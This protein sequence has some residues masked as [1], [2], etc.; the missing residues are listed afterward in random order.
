MK[1]IQQVH[2]LMNFLCLHAQIDQINFWGPKIIF[3]KTRKNENELMT[4]AALTL[5][6]N[7][8]LQIGE[9]VLTASAEEEE[10]KLLILI[11]LQRQVVINSQLNEET[12]DLTLEFDDNM[13]LIVYGN[14]G[15]N[16][17]WELGAFTF[18]DY[19]GV[20][21]TPRKNLAVNLPENGEIDYTNG[22]VLFL[23]YSDE[24]I[25]VAQFENVLPI[26]EERSYSKGDLWHGHA[27]YIRRKRSSIQ[28]ESPTSKSFDVTEEVEQMM[29]LLDDKKD[30]ILRLKQKYNMELYIHVV[31]NIEEANM[32]YAELSAEHMQLLSQLHAPF[33]VYVYDMTK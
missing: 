32:P 13:K 8:A 15:E 11:K 30:A 23:M 22:Y 5:E 27:P 2:E 4:E 1:R 31:L 28:I 18:K 19:I 14:N 20:A 21:A 25:E 3:A 17:A 6:G 9:E 12:N 10:L 7:L 29:N 16:N 26:K 33:Q 24:E